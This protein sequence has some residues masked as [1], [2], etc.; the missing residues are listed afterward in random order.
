MDI[1][2]EIFCE[3]LLKEFFFLFR[4]ACSS[5]REDRK[6]ESSKWCHA[7]LLD[8]LIQMNFTKLLISITLNALQRK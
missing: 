2:G 4:D 7:F 6:C 3:C 5:R 8:N 1:S